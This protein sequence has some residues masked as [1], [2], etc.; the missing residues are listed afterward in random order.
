MSLWH[1]PPKRQHFILCFSLGPACHCGRS[2]PFVTPESLSTPPAS[3][4]P[5]LSPSPACHCG[6]SRRVFSSLVFHHANSLP[7]LPPTKVRLVIVTGLALSYFFLDT[8]PFLPTHQDPACHCGRSR[9]ISLHSLLCPHIF[10]LSLSPPQVR[11]VIVAG[12]AAS[13]SFLATH[14]HTFLPSFPCIKAGLSLW[15][16]SPITTP[17][18]H[19]LILYPVLSRLSPPL[20]SFLLPPR[21]R[22]APWEIQSDLADALPW[23]IHKWSCWQHVRRGLQVSVHWRV[24]LCFILQITNY[25]GW[26]AWLCFALASHCNFVERY[27]V[28]VELFHVAEQNWVDSERTLRRPPLFHSLLSC[29]CAL[30]FLARYLFHSDDVA[31]M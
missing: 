11:L 24:W 8:H 19:P 30:H 21:A 31:M 12:P 1:V 9:L 16:V 25:L 23:S 14:S 27:F 2:R 28:T 4:L 17:L 13:Y 22:R 26:I 20:T 5:S 7:S 6:R 15:Q 29:A 10:R 18:S 3:T